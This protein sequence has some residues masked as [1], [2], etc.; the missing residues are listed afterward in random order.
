VPTLVLHGERDFVP[1]DAAT[2]IADAIPTA[3]LAVVRR[4]G[5]FAHLEAPDA[6]VRH[7]RDLIDAEPVSA[8]RPV[9]G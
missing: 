7:V 2:H 3:H 5:H 6:V 9:G 4:C 8:C 1:I